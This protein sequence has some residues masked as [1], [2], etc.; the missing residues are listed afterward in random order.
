MQKWHI[1]IV[2]RFGRE[3]KAKLAIDES[4]SEEDE[5][6]KESVTDMI[7]SA[8][9]TAEKELKQTE[10]ERIEAA[11]ARYEISYILCWI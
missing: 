8:A 4:E 2:C 1:F 10:E 7:K 5:G 6:K 9:K 3:I 11:A